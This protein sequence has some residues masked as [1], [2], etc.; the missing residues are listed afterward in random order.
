MENNT[1][2]LKK[3]I[4]IDMDAFYASVEQRDFPELR[5][6][7]IA[8]GGGSER[9]VVC[10][11]SY[12]ARKFGV[13]SAMSGIKARNLCPDLIFVKTRFDAYK[14]VSAQIRE[15]FFDYTDLVEPL[16]LDEAY[17]DVT[18]N[19]S[20]IP[21]ATKLAK[22][23]LTRIYK[24]TGLTASAGVSYNK[25]LAKSASDINKPAG[26]KVILP[27]EAAEFLENLPIEKFH[28]IGKVTA[29]K[30]KSHNIF[31]G[32]DLKKISEH[33][34]HQRFGKSGLYYYNIVRGIDNRVVNPNSVRKSISAEST[35][36]Q[37]ITDKD[38]IIQEINNISEELYARCQ[39]SKTKG[40]TL[41]LKI[42]YADFKIIS[43][44]ITIETVIM[45]LDQMKELALHL[46]EKIEL[47]NAVRLIGLGIASLK[48]ENVEAEEKEQ[49]LLDLKEA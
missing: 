17:L 39:K 32:I 37:N 34:L 30:M 31:R 43:R 15:I 19:K 40:Y 26:M 12:E 3:I 28:G 18:E 6:K 9:G 27:D 38:N 44:R 35:F 49:F 48:E 29:A 22:E 5:G 45:E 36:G 41:V 16:S 46:L 47:E 33:A 4:H 7:P 25:F 8:V 2:D 21:Y 20:N 23:I 13:R 10:T 14:K 42:K 1:P 11:A 24:E